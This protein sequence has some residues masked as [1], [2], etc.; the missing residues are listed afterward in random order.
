[1]NKLKLGFTISLLLSSVN[2]FATELNTLTPE[3]DAVITTEIINAITN[4]VSGSNLSIENIKQLDKTNN[5]MFK[6]KENGEYQTMTY[7]K[8]LNTLILSGEFFNLKDKSFTNRDFDATFN[9]N[10]LKS[11]KASDTIDNI[12][13]NEKHSVF[14]FTD[15]TC[16]YC[17]KLNREMKDYTDA[18]ITVK[19]LPFPRSGLTGFAHDAL[20]NTL[21]SA[22]PVEAL[23]IAET[24]GTLPN[25]K[26][27]T[28]PEQLQVCK[29]EVKAS[30]ELGQKL[31]VSGTP[32]IFLNDGTKLGGYIP[33]HQLA[34]ML[35]NKK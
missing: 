15:P 13:P 30:Y 3:Q 7:L 23:Y 21:C 19:Y 16:G 2:A 26:E 27:G 25:V 32:T 24:K 33:A 18:G 34:A 1:M 11:I 28:T 20:V 22:N 5:Y 31:G 17:Q 35:E 9:K 10:F 4:G 14:V 29:D 6:Y 12:A 8:D